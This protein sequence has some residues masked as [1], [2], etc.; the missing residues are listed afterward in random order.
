MTSTRQNPKKTRADA[1]TDPLNDQ[2]GAVGGEPEPESTSVEQLSGLLHR[3]MQQQDERWNKMQEDISHLQREMQQSRAEQR[4]DPGELRAEE[5][6]TQSSHYDQ[7][8]SRHS[9]TTRNSWKGPKMQPYTDGEDIEHYLCTFERIAHA[10]QW[11]CDE[12]ALRLAPLLTGKARSAYVAMDIDDTMN[13]N[14]VKRAVLQKFEIST[15]TYR[16]RFRSTELGEEESPRELQVRLKELYYKWMDPKTK[17]K[18]EIGDTIVLEQFLRILSPELHT[19]IKERDPK[20]SKE[21][22]DMAE[23]FLAARRPSKTLLAPKPHPP[24]PLGKTFVPEPRPSYFRPSGAFQHA[25][26]SDGDRSN[27]ACHLC[28]Q[29]GHLK[30]QCPKA[31]SRSSKNYMCSVTNL[32]DKVDQSEAHQ[33]DLTMG[34]VIDDKPCIALLDSGS[35]RTLVRQDS[36]PKDVIFCGGTVDIVCIH[37][38]RVRYPIAEVTVQVEGQSFALLVGVLEQLPYQIVLGLDLPILSELIA[39]QS[40]EAKSDF[41]DCLMAVTRSHSQHKAT[42]QR[43]GWE[44][45]PFANA[46]MLNANN[47]KVK[48]SKRQKR[49]EKVKG[50]RLKEK[51][52]QPIESELFPIG[53]DVA[54]LQ[55]QDSTLANL[56][57]KC[58]PETTT[59]TSRGKEVFVI[60]EGKLYRRSEIGDQL[61]VPQTLRSTIL[62]LSHSIPWAGHLG[63]AKTFSRMVPRFY[64]PQQYSDTVKYCQSCPECQLTAPNK[65]G[66]RAPLI[67]MPIIDTPFARIAMD[68]VGPLERSSAGHRY[69]LVVSDY[70]TRYPEAFP[71]KK[72]KARQIVTCL[73]QLFSRVGIPKEIITDQGTNFTSSLLKQVYSL[74][75]IQGIKTS[76]YHPQTDGLVER[77]NK[78]LKSMLRK[79]V[80]GS[81]SDWNQWLPFLMFAY[82]EVPQTSTGF[83]PF[84]LLY[85][86]SVRGPM[87][88]LK[89]AWEG[90]TPEQGCSELS[91]V[92]KM[93]D[94]LEQ[95]KELACNNLMQAQERQKHSYDKASRR[96]AF[97]VGQKVLLLLPTLESGLLAKWQGPYEI[98]QK[99]GPVTYELCMPERRKK[100]QVFHINLLKEWVDR[101]NQLS[102]LARAV[103]DEEELQ[104]QYFPLPA[105]TPVFPD[106][107]HLSTEQQ[108]ELQV[109]MTKELFSERPGYTHLIQHQIRL[110]ALEQ[111]PIRDTTCRIPAKLGPELKKEV[112]EMLET[113][114]IEPSRSEWC[115]PVVL[116][117]KKEDPKL[118]FC[119]N[120]SKLNAVSAFDPYP[121]PRVDE[122]IERLGHARYLTTLDLCKG[123]WQVP[124]EEGSKDFTTFRVPSGLFRFRMMPFGLHG[125][126]ATFQRLVDEVFIS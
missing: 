64:W 74:L 20:T 17:T 90:P 98:H 122:L 50:T 66:D 109:Y 91:Y 78:T 7:M 92:L 102:L 70:A 8:Y 84:Q 46:D 52:L 48:K 85:G 86:H 112:E 97:K 49:Q 113:G 95:F 43:T 11:P 44:E 38:D 42:S 105:E 28:G 107:T 55:K 14:R 2:P 5:P 65:K 111:Q 106:V 29:I 6:P 16:R 1:G 77:F 71:L 89:D 63:Q 116:V 33:E 24:I 117:P 108:Q 76:P 58:V 47:G 10:C 53:S 120:F 68:I 21:A 9:S 34:V 81:G 61:V 40:T 75:G 36:L 115:S 125:A 60:K 19:W 99:T 96:R 124:L 15:E 69:I 101:P 67:S 119:V 118:R 72:I 12:W 110:R 121:M 22:A 79:F 4:E 25:P 87:D 73:I 123:Y 103:I 82:R 80:A 100:Y 54:K 104:E 37:G 18:E 32:P 3:L 35:D 93:R 39:K 26:R 59:V 62:N 88:V 27:Y 56:Y 114:I 13:Y 51:I 83:S 94:K 126:P 31:N 23:A 30:A 57:S 41:N 45:L